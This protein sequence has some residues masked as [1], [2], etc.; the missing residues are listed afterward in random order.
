MGASGAPKPPRA[1]TGKRFDDTIVH[2]EDGEQHD[3]M[4]FLRTTLRTRHG[5]IPYTVPY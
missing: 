5:R 3:A 1:K 4:L 2:T